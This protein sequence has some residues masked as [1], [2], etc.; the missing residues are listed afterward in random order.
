MMGLEESAIDSNTS[1]MCSGEYVLNSYFTYGCW[2]KLGHG[3]LKLKRAIAESCD[4]FFY[5][6]GLALGIAKMEYY[7]AILSLGVPTGIDLPNEKS[8]VYPSREWKR[9]VHKAE[10]YPGDT[11]NLSIGQGF[12]TTTPLQA[13]VMIGSIFNG[14]KVFKPHVVKS[15]LNNKNRVKEE[16]EPQLVHQISISNNTRQQISEGMVEAVYTFGG[17]ARRAALKEVKVAG[18]TG[19]A[20]VASMKITKAYEERKQEIPEKYKDHAWF[21]GVF[22]AENPKYVI[23]VLAE[24]AGGGG[25]VAAPIAAEV[26]KKVVE[27]GYLQENK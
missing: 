16:V 12:L 2:K 7:S 8:G 6:L 25:A 24:N 19:T 15:I 11:I 10:W 18:K 21:T 26:I 27:K 4:V 23:V 20:Q 5:N 13:A 17:T 9:R 1:Y 22:P 3:R 14:G